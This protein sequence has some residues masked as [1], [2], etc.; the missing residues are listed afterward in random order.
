FQD[1]QLEG[2]EI[3]ETGVAGAEIV[4]CYRVALLTQLADAPA[5]Q[6]AI[7]QGALGQLQFD[8]AGGQTR[9]TQAGVQ[10]PDQ[11]LRL[12]ILGRQVDIDG[13]SGVRLHQGTQ[14]TQHQL[15]YGQGQI[16]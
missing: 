10:R 14:V 8:G 12:Q 5:R 15:Q 13:D 11:P 7:E 2:F 9:L 4:D 3:G 16:G 1:I 6:L